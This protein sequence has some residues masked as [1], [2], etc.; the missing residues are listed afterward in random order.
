MRN[1][2]VRVK[3][4][5]SVADRLNDAARAKGMLP[6][7]LAAFVVGDYLEKRDKEAR[8]QELIA[9]DTAGRM[10]EAFAAGSIPFELSPGTADLLRQVLSL[11]ESEGGLAGGTGSSASPEAAAHGA[12]GCAA[13]PCAV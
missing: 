7:T 9:R 8:L 12:G 13:V 4:E 1:A 11:P 3:L 2:E 10:L 6:A 5:P